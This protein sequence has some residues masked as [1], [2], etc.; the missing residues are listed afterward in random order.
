M[1]FININDFVVRKKLLDESP[2][3]CAY[4]HTYRVSLSLMVEHRNSALTQFQLGGDTNYLHQHSEE[5]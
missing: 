3:L 1:T 5:N 2:F 4:I